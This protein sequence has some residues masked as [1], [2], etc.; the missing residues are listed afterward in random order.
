MS[1][2]C[3]ADLTENVLLLFKIDCTDCTPVVEGEAQSLYGNRTSIE[4]VIKL[5]GNKWDRPIVTQACSLQHL[6]P[7]L[8]LTTECT[9]STGGGKKVFGSNTTFLLTLLVKMQLK[10]QQSNEANNLIA[11]CEMCLSK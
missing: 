2:I 1:E 9:R 4:L 11:M 6:H 5:E 8:R 10:L 7:R 3:E